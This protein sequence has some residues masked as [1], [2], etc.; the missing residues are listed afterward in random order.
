MMIS[1]LPLTDVRAPVMHF[2]FAVL[3]TE[4]AN[5]SKLGSARVQGFK[6]VRELGRH[7]PVHAE[8][9]SQHG[10]SSA[11]RVNYT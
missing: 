9:H 6:F 2:Q 7:S 4:R 8:A 3:N 10:R 1:Y 5:N 11:R